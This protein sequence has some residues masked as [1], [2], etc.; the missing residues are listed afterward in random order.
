MARGRETHHGVLGTKVVDDEGTANGPRHIEQTA[1]KS[2]NGDRVPVLTTYLITVAQP[3]TIL[4]AVLPPVM[5]RE[6]QTLAF[7]GGARVHTYPRP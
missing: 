3:N 5:L 7:Y 4:S 6:D 1:E 2:I